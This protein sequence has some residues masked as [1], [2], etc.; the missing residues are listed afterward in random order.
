LLPGCTPGV[1]AERLSRGQQRSVARALL[2]PA[3]QRFT[4]WCRSRYRCCF[5]H[6]EPQIRAELTPALGRAM[7]CSRHGSGRKRSLLAAPA[8]FV[9]SLVIRSIAGIVGPV[10]ALIGD[11]QASLA[12]LATC[13]VAILIIIT[14]VSCPCIGALDG[15]CTYGRDGD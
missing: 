13:L 1:S 7:I 14:F 15:C 11:A 5:H 12:I 6:L 2:P 3:D 4:G 9:A 8:G 10:M